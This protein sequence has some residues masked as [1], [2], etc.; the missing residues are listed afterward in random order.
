MADTAAQ[1]DA[2]R[3]VVAKFL[4]AHFAGALRLCRTRG[5][6]EMHNPIFRPHTGFLSSS[7]QDSSSSTIHGGCF[8]LYS[9][10]S[11][12]RFLASSG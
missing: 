10:R 11:W 9:S 2:E 12:S 5:R 4:P 8:F 3:W 7:T 6:G 1:L